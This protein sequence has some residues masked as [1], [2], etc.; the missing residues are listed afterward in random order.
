MRFSEEEG[1]KGRYEGYDVY[2]C[3]L[4]GLRVAEALKESV[5]MPTRFGGCD[6]WWNYRHNGTKR[7]S[8][9][10]FAKAYGDAPTKWKLTNDCRRKLLA[11]IQ[12]TSYFLKNTM[13]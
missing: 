1:R 12:I 13:K 9:P 7:F 5:E 10:V 11:K 4:C 2:Y 3:D 6:T 8:V